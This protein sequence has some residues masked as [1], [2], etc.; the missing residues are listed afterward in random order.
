MSVENVRPEPKLELA[1]FKHDGEEG[2]YVT[3]WGDGKIRG[4]ERELT[5]TP[6]VARVAA[7][8]TT[9]TPMR[10]ASRRSVS[11]LEEAINPL[12]VRRPVGPARDTGNDVVGIV[13]ERRVRTEPACAREL[14]PAR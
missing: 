8:S 10:R 3:S 5:R 1:G 4:E 14:R 6:R 13:V 12:R 11:Q 9:E 2:Y 7:P